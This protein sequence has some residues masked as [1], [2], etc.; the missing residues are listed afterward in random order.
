M[1]ATPIE[2]RLPPERGRPLFG[3][4]GYAIRAAKALPAPARERLLDAV[5]GG[6]STNLPPF[7]DVLRLVEAARGAPDGTRW[8]QRLLDERP[9]LRAVRT[10]DIDDGTVRARLYL[11]PQDAPAATSAFVWIH[12]GAFVLGSLDAREA[13]WVAI[14]LAAAGITVLSVE[15]RMCIDGVHF[16]APHDDAMAAW[17]WATEHDDRLGVTADQLHLGG[18]SAGACIAAGVA[19]RLRDE[20]Q[21][22]PASLYLAYPVLEGHLPEATPEMTA[23]LGDARVPADEWIADMF[24]NWAGPASWS[25][26][27][28]S[29]GLTDPTGLPP[30]YVLTCGRDSLR[31][32]SEPYVDRLRAAGVPVWH[33]I[34]EDS[35]H[36]TFDRL[37]TPDAEHHLERLQSWLAASG[38]PTWEQA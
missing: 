23:G 12:G 20:G 26:P 28:V 34:S 33:D 3:A 18:A 36:A 5:T 9:N 27:Y 21:Q 29:P 6:V 17:T 24:S 4:I 32:S 2:H 31:R 35:E 7:P 30:T 1:S 10:Q 11:P 38:N 22:A 16:P 13:H 15:Y 25:D 14:E 37:G 19:L 8:Q